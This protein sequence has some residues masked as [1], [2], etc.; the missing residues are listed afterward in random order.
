MIDNKKILAIILARGGSKGI[1]GK[2]IK[3][4]AGKPLIAYTIEEALKS[5]YIDKLILSTDDKEIAEVGEKHGAQVPFL[6]PKKLAT[7]TATSEKA[8]LHTINCMEKNKDFNSQL[9]M[10]LQPT[11]P[12]RKVEDIDN[13][14]EKIID[15]KGDSLI[16]LSKAEK[17]PYWMMEIRDGKVVPY[18]ENKRKKYTRRQDLPEIYNINGA[19]Y[20]TDTKLFKETLNRWAGKTIPYLMPKKRSVD[21]DDMLDWRLAEVLLE[22]EK[23]E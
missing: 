8:M 21:I 16:G 1:P 15:K 10:L 13:S 20:I 2:N 18:N 14:I 6:R 9:V 4:L 23:N 3:N 11:S 12:L 22:E 19:I 7:D 17:H 5:K